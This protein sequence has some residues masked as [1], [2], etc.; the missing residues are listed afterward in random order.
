MATATVLLGLLC[1]GYGIKISLE[2][3]AWKQ[4]NKHLLNRITNEQANI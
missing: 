2:N 3:R 4:E 1:V